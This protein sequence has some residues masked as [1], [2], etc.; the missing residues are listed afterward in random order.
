VDRADIEIRWKPQS[1]YP[2]R[3]RLLKLIDCA[4]RAIAPYVADVADRA[5]ADRSWRVPPL[6][7][8]I[9]LLRHTV[10]HLCSLHEELRS[11]GYRMSSHYT[12][13]WKWG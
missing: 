8:L 11:R 5:L 10:W 4:R 12:K 3:K 2:S 6:H 13:T 1:A 7:K 9:Y